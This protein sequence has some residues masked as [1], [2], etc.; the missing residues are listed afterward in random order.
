MLCSFNKAIINA[1][2]RAASALRQRHQGGLHSALPEVS[3]DRDE[4]AE[5]GAHGFHPV[6]ML[7]LGKMVARMIS[8]IISSK[9][10]DSDSFFQ[11]GRAW[12]IT[13]GSWVIPVYEGQIT[14]EKA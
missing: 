13:I 6:S 11:L 14:I 1:L 10:H 2:H 3:G 8:I 7:Y 4:A 9:F 12:P 5:G